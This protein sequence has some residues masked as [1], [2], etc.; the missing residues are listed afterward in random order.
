MNAPAAA[1]SLSTD[2]VIAGKAGGVGY[3]RLNQP[4]KHN[5]ISYAMWIA[6]AEAME[7]FR[8]DGDVRVVVMSGRA[9]VRSRPARTSPSSPRTAAPRRKSKPTRRRAVPR[10]M[11][12]RTSRSRLSRGSKATASAAGSRLHYARTYASQP[13][14]PGSAFP[15]RSLASGTHTRACARSSTSSG[16]PMRRRFCSPPSVSPP[17]RRS[18]WGS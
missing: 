9:D 14:I 1:V 8:N 6:I 18:G 3:L 15:P 4:E 12:S 16:R 17:P 13:T 10:T 2:K 11:R 5:A 7:S